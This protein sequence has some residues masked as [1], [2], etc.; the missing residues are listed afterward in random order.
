M[1]FWITFIFSLILTGSMIGFGYLF[2]KRPPKQINS[3]FGYRTSMSSK[4]NE[5]WK[6]AHKYAGKVWLWEGIITLIISL[7]LIFIY[8]DSPS[9]EK[10]AIS[11]EVGIMIIILSVIPITEVALRK[12]FDKHG[13]E[14]LN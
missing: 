13:K 14:K 6:Y 9:F 10:I 1:S 5:T 8:K 2:I 11:V 7:I 4:N 3:F 12:K